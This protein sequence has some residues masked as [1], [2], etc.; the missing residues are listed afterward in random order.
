MKMKRELA[1]TGLA[2]IVSILL[3]SPSLAQ[4]QEHDRSVQDRYTLT[5]QTSD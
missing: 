1:L 2:L 4:P 3:S 5:M